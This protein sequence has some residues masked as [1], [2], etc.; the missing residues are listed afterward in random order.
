[1][2]GFYLNRERGIAQF[3]D[4]SLMQL[5]QTCRLHLESAVLWLAG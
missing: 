5:L 2:K 3:S 1:M 4:T